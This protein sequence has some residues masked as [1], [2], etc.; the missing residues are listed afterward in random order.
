MT[1]EELLR[2]ALSGEINKSHK[3]SLGFDE[4]EKFADAFHLK[5][6]VGKNIPCQV[7][8]LFYYEWTQESKRRPE[9]YSIFVKIMAKHVQSKPWSCMDTHR[10]F[11]AY[12]IEGFPP[13]TRADEERAR[14]LV[15]EQKARIKK[16]KGRST[17]KVL[18]P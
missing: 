14:K 3:N 18:Q 10:H 4:A 12:K 16:K 5:Y 2:I 8:Y 13:Y 1:K 17:K 11:R 15:R 6:G 9:N 7:V